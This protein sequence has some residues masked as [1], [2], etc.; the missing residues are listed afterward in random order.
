MRK[1]TTYRV[2]IQREP[3]GPLTTRRVLA[4]ARRDVM[5]YV[6]EQCIKIREAD[7]DDGIE[8]AERG[9]AEEDITAQ[10]AAAEPAVEPQVGQ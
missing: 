3:D 8:F 7:F 1:P 2:D 9:I 4:H 10:P 6:A 5:R